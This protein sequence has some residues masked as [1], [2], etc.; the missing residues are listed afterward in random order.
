MKSKGKGRQS[1]KKNTDYQKE[2]DYDVE[3]RFRRVRNY[4]GGNYGGVNNSGISTS[5]N[6]CSPEEKSATSISSQIHTPNITIATDSGTLYHVYNKFDEKISSFT[7]ANEQAHAEL[8]KEYEKK[9]EES[10]FKIENKL[11]QISKD[12]KERLPIQWYIW[13]VSAIVI[14]AALI[15]ELSYSRILNQQEN[16]NDSIQRINEEKAVLNNEFKHIKNHIEVLDKSIQDL[17][18]KKR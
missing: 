14:F 7:I 3:S 6:G 10:V 12:V 8:R 15:Y 13:T 1:S 16:N 2:T 11:D 9:I 5:S 4:Q 17:K 18:Q